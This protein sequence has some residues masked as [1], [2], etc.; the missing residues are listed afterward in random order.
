MAERK[1]AHGAVH[2]R[3]GPGALV[4]V[5]RSRKA[6]WRGK[7]WAPAGLPPPF[8]APDRNFAHFLSGLACQFFAMRSISALFLA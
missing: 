7:P 4:E 5:R 2:R 6:A 1:L 8:A 3:S